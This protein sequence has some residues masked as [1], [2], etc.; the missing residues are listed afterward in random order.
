MLIP[1]KYIFTPKISQYLQIIEAAKSVIDTINIP[2]EVGMNIRRQ[3]LLKSSL[4][5]ARIEGNTLTLEELTRIP[6][7]DQKKVE[8]INIL[9]GLQMVQK[10]G[11]RDLTITFIK[12]LHKKVMSGL[13][14]KGTI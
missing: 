12:D 9:K 3:N 5:S 8:V 4:F 13:G 14:E 10:R 7:K 6:S 1:P 11:A 2:P